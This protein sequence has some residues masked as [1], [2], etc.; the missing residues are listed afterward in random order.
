MGFSRFSVVLDAK[1]FNPGQTVKGNVIVTAAKGVA[2]RNITVTIKGVEVVSWQE[3]TPNVNYNSNEEEGYG[4]GSTNA[5]TETFSYDAKQ[6]LFQQPVIVWTDPNKTMAPGNHVFP[7]SFILPRNIPPSYT[8]EFGNVTYKVEAEADRPMAFNDKDKALFCVHSMYDLNL[9]PLAKKP[10]RL[11]AETS[12][13]CWC[14]EGTV[15]MDMVA[16]R[17]G[18]VAGERIVVNGEVK[19]YSSSSIDYTEIKLIQVTTFKA[20][21]KTKTVKQVL[22][23]VR[24]PRVEG[25]GRDVWASVSLPVPDVPATQNELG[26][27]INITYTLMLKARLGFIRKMTVTAPVHIG[28]VPLKHN[29]T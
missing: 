23:R 8:S 3:E 18:Y 1:A 22:S 7:F 11:Q 20:T 13:G 10:I 15:E 14:N 16:E 21:S 4:E 25:G 26:N 28:K 17:T 9:D 6:V 12:Y 19:N 29:P 2:C 27:I 5:E 24:R